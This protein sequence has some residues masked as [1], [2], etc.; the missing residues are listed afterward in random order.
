[1]L[2][3]FDTHNSVIVRVD[4]SQKGLGATLLQD[5]HPVAFTSMAFTPVEQHYANRECE[6]LTFVFRAE[7]FHTYVV[8]IVYTQDLYN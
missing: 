7:W 3:Y 2:W 8:S 6:L 4:A 1:M 5:G